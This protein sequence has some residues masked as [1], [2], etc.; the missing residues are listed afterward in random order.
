M[1]FDS[2]TKKSSRVTATTLSHPLIA[3]GTTAFIRSVVG[4][5]LHNIQKLGGK[6]VSVTT[7][8]FITNVEDLE[9]NY[10]HYH[11][12]KLF[13]FKSTEPSLRGRKDMCDSSEALEIKYEGKGILSLTT[14]GQLGIGS[15]IAEAT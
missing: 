4:E 11:L 9:K 2:L 1:N 13:Y 5:C 7:D 6:V 12:I 14:R 3:Q 8:S 10:Y 15:K